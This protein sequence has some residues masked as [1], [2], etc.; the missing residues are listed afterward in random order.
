MASLRIVPGRSILAVGSVVLVT[1]PSWC[2]AQTTPSGV[3][4][5]PT[6]TTVESNPSLT[7][8]RS[9]PESGFEWGLGVGF[10]VPFGDAD[11]GA[12]LFDSGG[13]APITGLQLRDGGM[14]GIVSYRVPFILDLGYRIS[15]RWWVGLRPEF[16]TG[17]F[18]TEC[19]TT[20]RCSW[21]DARL[22]AVAKW[23]VDPSSRSD[24]WLG[25]NL[26]WEWLRSSASVL[27]PPE[28]TGTSS[29][30][31]VTAR[32][33]I[34]G[35]LLEALGGL[36]FHFGE[37]IHAGPFV[38]AAVG[39]YLRSSY[40]CLSAALGCPSPSWIEDGAFHAWLS[41]G[42]SGTHGP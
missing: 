32:Q 3:Q 21:T 12:S 8:Q 31:G 42:I 2:L 18:G 38:S 14:D 1:F 11:S 41:I 35:P 27:L 5:S 23:H 34:A 26:G 6:P 9:L 10:S 19:P 40:D 13:Q 20:A 7:T 36:S 24:P 28:V 37:N 4:P 17:G 25:L 39:R 22:G 33:T 29:N 16:G 30:Q 15:P